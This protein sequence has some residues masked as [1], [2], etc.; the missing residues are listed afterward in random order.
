MPV[1]IWGVDVTQ[2]LPRAKFVSG[3]LGLT[4]PDGTLVAYPDLDKN[5]T[6]VERLADGQTWEIDTQGRNISFTPD[7]RRITWSIFDEDAPPETR[8]ETMWLA[9][10]NGRNARVL[11]QAARTN[12]AAWLADDKLL[13]TRSIPRS[14]DQELFILS[15]ADGS[16]TELGQFP[17]MRGQS[18]S[19]DRRHLVYYVSFEPETHKNGLWLLDLQNPTQAPQKLPFFGAYRWRDSERLIYIPFDPAATEHN[20]YEYNI[21]T[22]QSRAL[23]PG[24]TALTIANNDWRVSPDGNKI[25]LLAAKGAEFDGIWVLDIN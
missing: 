22:N 21:I 8:P 12:A 19:P 7:S 15:L 24:G 16:Q 3:W 18:L 2:P 9:D 6:V 4:S 5:V 1:G 20:F 17:R 23:F 14:F 13:M 11:F 25:A 10:V